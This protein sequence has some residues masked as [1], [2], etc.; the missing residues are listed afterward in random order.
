MSVD[1][2]KEKIAYYKDLL[3][4]KLAQQGDPGSSAIENSTVDT[5]SSTIDTSG[6]TGLN[7]DTSEQLAEIT[8]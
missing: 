6:A 8:Q 5:S 4:K 7:E 3:D 2:I 1:Q